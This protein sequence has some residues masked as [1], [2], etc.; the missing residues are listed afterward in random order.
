MALVGD[1][2]LTNC[3]CIA[4]I[5]GVVVIGAI[6]E[7]TV[8]NVA[9]LRGM[10]FRVDMSGDR[11]LLHV[12]DMMTLVGS[13]IECIASLGLVDDTSVCVL[14]SP[15]CDLVP[16]AGS[17]TAAIGAA[18]EATAGVPVSLMVAVDL[19]KGSQIPSIL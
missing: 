4:W 15:G 5:I 9:E 3:G 17:I 7:C 19:N 10:E 8:L 11:R 12:G 16:S 18:N 1:E 6:V 13:F 14:L 2:L